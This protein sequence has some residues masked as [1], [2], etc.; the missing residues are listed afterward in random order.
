MITADNLSRAHPTDLDALR[1]ALAASNPDV[2]LNPIAISRIEIGPDALYILTEAVTEL[3]RGERV[4]LRLTSRPRTA[5]GMTLKNGVAVVRG[6]RH[7]RQHIHHGEHKKRKSIEAPAVRNEG[8][9][10]RAKTA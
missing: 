9:A 3:T 1:E 5:A 8:D 7:Y 4:V 6:S 2:R 10:R